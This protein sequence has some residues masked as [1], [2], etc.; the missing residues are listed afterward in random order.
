MDHKEIFM[1]FGHHTVLGMKAQQLLLGSIRERR[2]VPAMW[3]RTLHEGSF[4]DRWR[5]HLHCDSEHS[6]RLPRKWA[7]KAP[8]WLLLRDTE[9]QGNRA[10]QLV[11]L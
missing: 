10:Q 7:G 9:R 8:L 5:V 6:V 3:P 11:L 1:S 4:S 2:E